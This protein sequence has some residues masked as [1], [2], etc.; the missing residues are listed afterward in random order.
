MT[1]IE[2]SLKSPNLNRGGASSTG[3]AVALLLIVSALAAGFALY[4]FNLKGQLDETRAALDA[5]SALA[6]SLQSQLSEAWS[7]S[8]S[9]RAENLA[10]SANLSLLS[11][12]YSSL[13]SSYNALQSRYSSALS[14]YA[15]L[16][17]SVEATMDYILSYASLTEAFPRTINDKEVKATASAVS[18]AGVTASNTWA[19]YE[20]IYNYIKSRI[21]YVNDVEV[22]YISR[23]QYVSLPDAGGRSWS[24]YAESVSTGTWRNYVQSPSQ[25]LKLEQG[26]CEDQAILAYA[27]LKYYMKY[28][29]GTEYSLYLAYIEFNSADSAHLAVFIPVQ[30]GNLCVLDPAGSYLTR[31]WGSIA[32]KPAAQELSSYSAWWSDEGGIAKITLYSVSATTG[33]YYVAAEGTLSQVAAHLS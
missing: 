14:E 23:I 16:S 26:D 19:S 24:Q 20:R 4:S 27:M 3:A 29:Y 10:L 8:S 1:L 15:E 9:L 25:T 2:T 22:P 32:S 31:S 12:D 5:Q 33:S 11:S 7:E 6:K 13:Q 30:G 17:R 18:S 21:T 28:V